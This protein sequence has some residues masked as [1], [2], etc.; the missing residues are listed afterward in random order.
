MQTLDF[1]EIESKVVRR[2]FSKAASEGR[3]LPVFDVTCQ[4][5]VDYAKENG[6]SKEHVFLLRDIFKPRMKSKTN[7]EVLDFANDIL[8]H[9]LRMREVY[10]KLDSIIAD[11]KEKGIY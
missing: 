9:I 10:E 7:D 3:L 4:L 1:A 6:F 11:K 5:N 8:Y 2:R